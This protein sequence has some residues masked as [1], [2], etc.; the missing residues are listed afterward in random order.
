M[1]AMS[2]GT[3]PVA[4][5][6]TDDSITYDSGNRL[7][8]CTRGPF[9]LTAIARYEVACTGG[10]LAVAGTAIASKDLVADFKLRRQTSHAQR[11]C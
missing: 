3:R 10:D 8:L 9:P 2:R 7:L 11:H 4:I 5:P 1:K 6:F